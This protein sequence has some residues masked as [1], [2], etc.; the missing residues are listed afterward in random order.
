M[1]LAWL[2][3]LLFAMSFWAL[4]FWGSLQILDRGNYKNT[5]GGA[6]LLALIA[7]ST[8][9]IGIPDLFYTGGWLVIVLRVL[10]SY[11]HVNLLR[12]LVVTAATVLAP[13]VVG[14]LL[15][16]LAVESELAGTALV[17]GLP[18]AVFGAWII[19]AVRKRRARIA[20]REVGMVDHTLPV[21]RVE[22]GGRT[23]AATP[24]PVIAAPPAAP[25]RSPE[26]V[27]ARTDKP[28]FL[29]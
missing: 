12:S 5:L 4:V 8:R 2:L 24:A 22:R 19:G 14:P 23:R 13:Y 20:A 29:T 26:V 25:L 1:A 21:A 9:M 7:C 15:L 17:Y 27:V 6:L 16:R 18:I 3:T 11:Y 28:T 10:V